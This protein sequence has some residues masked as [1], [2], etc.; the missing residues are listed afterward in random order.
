[1]ADIRKLD[2]DSAREIPEGLMMTFAANPSA[3][4]YFSSLSKDQQQRI[5][6]Y[7]QSSTSGTEAKERILNVVSMLGDGKSELF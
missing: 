1:M 4:T 7:V 6:D 5:I 2:I 3:M